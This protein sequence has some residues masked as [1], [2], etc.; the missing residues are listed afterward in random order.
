MNDFNFQHFNM[1]VFLF[2]HHPSTRCTT[3][4]RHTP[5]LTVKCK[6]SKRGSITKQLRV[7]TKP[8]QEKWNK[9]ISAQH[10]T[11]NAIKHA[12]CTST[13]TAP[14][15]T[16]SIITTSEEATK[17]LRRTTQNRNFWHM[18]QHLGL[19]ITKSK[20]ESQNHE[21]CWSTVDNYIKHSKLLLHQMINGPQY[22]S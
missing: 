7:C 10:S 20:H 13:T 8:S 3:Y 19:F 4:T 1:W 2:H 11:P 6:G 16:F 9:K 21:P 22:N 15:C 14:L 12:T 17:K 18:I 5:Q